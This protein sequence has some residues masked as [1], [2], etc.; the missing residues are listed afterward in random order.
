M[1]NLNQKV[2]LQVQQSGSFNSRKNRLDFLIPSGGVIDMS[3][4]YININTSIDG[5][6]T[7]IHV[8][9]V[10]FTDMGGTSMLHDNSILVKNIDVS[11]SKIGMLESIRRSDVL[12]SSLN[13][14]SQD[15]DTKLSKSHLSMASSVS[16]RKIGLSP[17]RILRTDAA[18]K[19]ID[20]D[21]RI[22]LSSIL[23]CGSISS[24]DMDKLGQTR[25]SM[26]C[27]FDKLSVGQYLGASDGAW[28][29]TT[30]GVLGLMDDAP[31]VPQTELS[32]LITAKKY[33]F[34]EFQNACPFYVGQ[35]IKISSKKNGAGAVLS[36]AVQITNI[37]YNIGN[38]SLYLST[39]TPWIT[40]LNGSTDDLTEIKVV[41]TDESG[42]LRINSA[43]IVLCYNSS[44]EAPSNYEIITYKEQEDNGGN[45]LSHNH[46]YQ[47][48]PEI[49]AVVVSFPNDNSI[50][51]DLPFDNYRCAVNNKRLTDRQIERASPLYYDRINRYFQNKG[52]SVKCLQERQL[53][54]TVIPKKTDADTV[55]YSN[56]NN[57]IFE[58]MPITNDMKLLNLEVNCSGSERVNDIVI[59]KEFLKSF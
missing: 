58:P 49:M 9:N 20:H 3:K 56:E 25:I 40:G 18:S 48:E 36:A 33:Q 45:R 47:L 52:Q 13:Q 30:D 44:S 1:S 59:H 16:S 8:L 51:S 11:S 21:L 24:L 19:E 5:D 17:Y 7:S 10:N 15:T 35:E 4:S 28:T 23:G 43:E 55:K 46:Q 39:N 27:N 42:T 26:E 32:S 54:K 6:G 2:K 12:R 34:E 38:L 29:D 53:N 14:Y 50:L 31:N 22:D 37:T 57:A 41:G